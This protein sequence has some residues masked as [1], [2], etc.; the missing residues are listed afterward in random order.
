MKRTYIALVAAALL[1][2][3]CLA[4]AGPNA[5]LKGYIIENNSKAAITLSTTGQFAPAKGD[6]FS[7]AKTV[8]PSQAAIFNLATANDPDYIQYNLADGS[9]HCLIQFSGLGSSLA[10]ATIIDV[11][12]NGMAN[13]KHNAN[14]NIVVM[15]ETI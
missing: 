13:C 8:A 6:D 7:N 10:P 14:S 4:L 3:S 1:G 15:S 11:V 2:A 5:T 12:A 9:G